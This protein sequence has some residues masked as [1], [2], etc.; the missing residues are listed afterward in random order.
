MF[1]TLFLEQN[2]KTQVWVQA[3]ETKG[4][5]TNSKITFRYLFFVV[6]CSIVYSTSASVVFWPLWEHWLRSRTRTKPSLP[7][8]HPQLIIERT[9]WG[10]WGK[11]FCTVLRQYTVYLL[12]TLGSLHRDLVQ[13]LFQFFVGLQA[14]GLLGILGLQLGRSLLWRRLQPVELLSEELRDRV[15]SI[16]KTQMFVYLSLIHSFNKLCCFFHTENNLF[17]NNFTT[18]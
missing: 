1:L 18:F 13:L 5:L 17:Y 4:L 10:N 8:L 12:L 14:W 7:R 6:L 15:L 9:F 16:Y 2:E 3:P 11:I